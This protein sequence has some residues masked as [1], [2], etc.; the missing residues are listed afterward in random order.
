MTRSTNEGR[1]LSAL[2]HYD[3][4][5]EPGARGFS[6]VLPADPSPV[7]AIDEWRRWDRSIIRRPT[8][9]NRY[10][11]ETARCGSVVKVILPRE[12]D[13]SDG[14]SCPDCVQAVI[15][16]TRAPERLDWTTRDL[17]PGP[18]SE[19]RLREIEEATEMARQEREAEIKFERA[20]AR[21]RQ[22][23][24]RKR[25]QAGNTEPQPDA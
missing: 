6:K 23:E 19:D 17:G 21:R 8:F 11:Y 22:L 13:L 3:G 25:K 9:L 14:D 5:R 16:G 15:N 18:L 20:A 24:A 7:H 1:I 12:F 4:G 2:D 10:D